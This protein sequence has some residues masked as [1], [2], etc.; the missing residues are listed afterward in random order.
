M[1]SIITCV[2][3]GSRRWPHIGSCLAKQRT[4]HCWARSLQTRHSPPTDADVMKTRQWEGDDHMKALLPVI[5]TGCRAN[6]LRL[7]ALPRETEYYKRS[8]QRHPIIIIIIIQLCE[9]KQEEEIQLGSR[10]WVI[11]RM[12]T[13]CLLVENHKGAEITKMFV[14]QS[15]TLKMYLCLFEPCWQDNVNR[16]K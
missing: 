11:S 3:F 13:C 12:E 15:C 10:W 14:T 6:T 7:C 2:M 1:C 16:K 9:A 4:H 5:E 8:T